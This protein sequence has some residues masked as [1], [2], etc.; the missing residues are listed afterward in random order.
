MID[1]SM[2]HPGDTI[3]IVDAWPTNK[4]RQNHRGLMDHWLGHNV[5]VL[6]IRGE[7]ITIREDAGEWSFNG[8]VTGHGIR[9]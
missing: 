3:R 1:L 7:E 5:T 6:G 9:K 2:L 4:S 8:E